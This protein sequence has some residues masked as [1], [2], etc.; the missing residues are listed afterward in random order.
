G[1]PSPAAPAEVSQGLFTVV[2][3]S[4]PQFNWSCQDE[5]NN[6]SN[7]YCRNPDNRAKPREQQARET[8]DFHISA[9]NEIK[10]NT[11][12]SRWWGGLVING[13]LTDFGSQNGHLDT[14]KNAYMGLGTVWPGLGNHDYANNV[15]DCGAQA[16]PV[17][18]YCAAEMVQFLA[19]IA[20]NRSWI[21]SR[22]VPTYSEN[23][24]QAG[25][26]RNVTGSLAYSW[27]IGNFHFVQ[28]N[29]YPTYTTSFKR[30]YSSGISS[31]DIN[32]TSPA[33]WLANDLMQAQRSGKKIILNWHRYGDIYSTSANNPAERDKLI[34]MLAPYAPSIKAIFVGHHHS[35]YGKL[36]DLTFPAI[37]GRPEIRVPVIYSGS[38]IYNRFIQA[39]FQT[40]PCMITTTVI[41]TIGGRATP[42]YS[43]NGS[44]GVYNI[45]C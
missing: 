19:D 30:G 29:N 25:S 45:N 37:F 7:D 39:D 18:N 5:Y 31:W 4:D 6:T 40:S 22:D 26:Q 41:N 44:T 42:D 14:F 23:W 2:I 33:G 3:M 1:N 17:W 24:G 43:S 36:D 28:L 10:R 32:I 27:D 34:G 8:N 20:R 13:D 38:A 21:T 12:A 15:N 11:S 16:T 35:M 9:I